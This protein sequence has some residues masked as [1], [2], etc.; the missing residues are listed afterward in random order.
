MERLPF[1]HK[2]YVI[3]TLAVEQGGEVT[4][5]K[6][7]YNWYEDEMYEGRLLSSY[8]QVIASSIHVEDAPRINIYIFLDAYDLE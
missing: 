1:I 2:L 3:F 7:M 8:F 6:Y 5:E 4:S